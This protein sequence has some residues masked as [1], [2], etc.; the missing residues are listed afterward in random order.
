MVE[1]ILKHSHT[2]DR[3]FM[4]TVGNAIFGNDSKFGK[5]FL[6]IDNRVGIEE[7]YDR[8]IIRIATHVNEEFLLKFDLDDANIDDV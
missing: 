1:L 7:L 5:R 4:K 2:D 6:I 8:L 3:Q